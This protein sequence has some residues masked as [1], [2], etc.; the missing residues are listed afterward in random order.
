MASTYSAMQCPNCGRSAI[1]DY[2][3]KIGEQF[4]CCHRCDYNYSKVIEHET[5]QYKEDAFGGYGIFMVVK[6]KGSREIIVLDGELTN[7]QLE[8]FTKIF[9]ESEVDQKS[10]YLVH[11][12]NGQFTILLGTSPKNYFLSFEDSLEKE[13]GETICF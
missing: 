11:F 5:S 13:I 1:E 4:I 2:Y 10:S 12:S 7:N 3:Y 8:K 9:S 6:K